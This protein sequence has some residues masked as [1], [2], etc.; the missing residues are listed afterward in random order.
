[1]PERRATIAPST[2][3]DGVQRLDLADGR[4][5]AYELV[6]PTTRNENDS[7]EGPDSSDPAAPVVLVVHGTPDSRLATPPDP[8]VPGVCQVLIDRPGF[9]DSDVDLG[10]TLASV[11][12]D[13]AELCG[14]LGVE[15]VGV[16]AWSAG[17]L[18]GLTLAAR[19]SALVSRLVLAAPLAPA[20]S[21][22]VAAPDRFGFDEADVADIAPLLVP[23]DVDLDLAIT[24]ALGDEAPHRTEVEAVPGAA[25]RLGES[26]LASV[27]S[28][29]V[30]L[31]RDLA[32]Q[33]TTP[34]LAAVVAPCHLVLGD[35]DA[36]C[37]PAMGAWLAEGL[38]S[39]DVT[40]ETLPGAGHA[41]P[42]VRWAELITA[43]AGL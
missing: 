27:R 5:L 23:P 4:R 38:V 22:P 2:D 6:G 26:V 30:G 43:A 35:A 8:A 40:V 36:V 39:A 19:H 17:A 31:E 33:L 1:M 28:G 18:F 16:M 20:E 37:P 25:Q 11:A 13:L 29:T 12:D 24:I 7:G 9:G 3:A 34:D 42:L 14:H 15:Q 32:A 41:F 10:A 21:W